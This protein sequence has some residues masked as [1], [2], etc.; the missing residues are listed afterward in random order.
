M[1]H[2]GLASIER[3]CH[4][5]VSIKIWDFLKPCFTENK[6]SIKDI[7]SFATAQFTCLNQ[8]DGNAENELQSLK[9]DIDRI[10]WAKAGEMLNVGNE[11]REL[12]KQH[13]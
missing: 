10:C 3:H 2:A 11:A 13:P 9:F 6:N 12:Q 5:G 7:G 4:K 8:G 1:K